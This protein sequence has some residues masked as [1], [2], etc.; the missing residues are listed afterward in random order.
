MAP[1]CTPVKHQ[2]S[3]LCGP[4][5]G[6]GTERHWLCP[7]PP[8][9]AAPLPQANFERVMGAVESGGFV[10]CDL[11]A[12]GSRMAG[13]TAKGQLIDWDVGA[14]LRC[15]PEGSMLYKRMSSMSLS[16]AKDVYARLLRQFP[17]LANTQD[18]RGWTILMHAVANS[19]PEITKLIINSVPP[20]SAKLGL[21]ASAVQNSILSS[22]RH[23]PRIKML[24]GTAGMLSTKRESAPGGALKRGSDGGTSAATPRVSM[25]AKEG[26]GANG[27][28]AAA[29]AA[30]VG[31]GQ[32]SPPPLSLLGK[33]GTFLRGSAEL[34]SPGGGQR[35]SAT[36]EGTPT[37]PLSPSSPRR[38]PALPPLDVHDLGPGR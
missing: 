7:V 17:L 1:L 6:A 26:A 27:D 21:T 25:R 9:H 33:V 16:R 14:E 5:T 35:S 8:A 31:S 20:M 34:R 32:E 13:C 37:S 18:S 3:A 10:R 38:P 22:I 15:V 28:M 12:T 2:C 23:V 11:S 30:A 24:V 36:G 19:N 29:A 4:L